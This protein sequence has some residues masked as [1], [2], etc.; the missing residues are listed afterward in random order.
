MVNMRKILSALLSATM[1]LLQLPVFAAGGDGTEQNP[2]KITTPEELQ[3]INQNLSAHYRL[4]NDLDLSGIDFEPLGNESVGAFT[5]TLDGNGFTVKNLTLEK[6]GNKYVGLVGCLE[7]TVKNIKLDNVTVN[8]QSARYVGSVAGFAEENALV[9]NC[10]TLS[11]SV[12]GSYVMVD[13]QLGGIAGYNKGTVRGCSNSVCINEEKTDIQ[14]NMVCGGIAGYNSGG[15]IENCEN[16]ADIFT[17]AS[18]NFT[19]YSYCGGIVGRNNIGKIVHCT[20]N[21]SISSRALSIYRYNNSYYYWAYSFSG[22]I[23]GHDSGTIL[24]CR[25]NGNISSYATSTQSSGSYGGSDYYSNSGAG[26]IAGAC[27]GNINK[28]INTGN[29]NSKSNSHKNY[30]GGISGYSNGSIISCDNLGNINADGSL[31]VRTS[32]YGGGIVGYNNTDIYHCV[33]YGKVYAKANDFGKGNWGGGYSYGGGIAGYSANGKVQSCQ[34]N[35]TIELYSTYDSY[36][37]GIVSQGTAYNCSNNSSIIHSGSPSTKYTYNIAPTAK[38]LYIKQPKINIKTNLTTAIPIELYGYDKDLKWTSADESIAVVDSKG[39]VTGVSAGE[40]IITAET[41]LGI[42]TSTT[43]VVSAESTGADIV[44]LNKI[45]ARL[46]P[47][48]TVQLTAEVTPADAT[49]P[50][51]WKSGDTS[52]ATVDA[53]GLVTAVKK[54]VT[55]I[56]ARIG[57]GRMFNCVINVVSDDVRVDVQSVTIH[58]SEITLAPND[59]AALNAVVSPSNATDAELKYTS[60]NED[61]ATVNAN[62]IVTAKS[63]GVAVIRAESSNGCYDEC[64]I[65]V[66]SADSASIVLNAEK[67]LSGDTAEVKA[68]I[69]KNP[70]I[71]AYKLNINYD[72]AA[73]TPVQ[74]T[75]NTDFKGTFTTNIE[76]ENKTN[77]Q[78]MWY[79]DEDTDLNAEL[80]NIT[81]K[82]SANAQIGDKYPVTAE[83]SAKDVYNTNGKHFAFYMQNTEIVVA[84]PL[85]GDIYEDG[86]VTAHDLTQLSRYVTHLEKLTNRQLVAADVNNDGAVNIKD[87]VR[88]SRY[89]VGWSGVELLSLPEEASGTPKI[90]FGNSAV[91]DEG[92]AEIPVSIQNNSGI[93][94]FVFKLDYNRDEVEILGITPNEK[95][96]ENLKTNLGKTDDD[97]LFVSWYQPTN[98]TENGEL[99]TIQ[100]RYLKDTASPVSIGYAD[101]CDKTEADIAIDY[102]SG[103]ILSDSFVIANE[104]L[105]NNAY[106]ADLYFDDTFKKQ[107]ATAIIAFY[108]SNNCL[109][110]CKTVDITVQPGMVDL[111]INYDEK[112][113]N[114]YKLRIWSRLDSMIPIT[115]IKQ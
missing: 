22:G 102:T 20:N 50:I 3:N 17:S 88:M 71:C 113:Y 82:V 99:F 54:G 11:G 81:F 101:I 109:V 31:S 26:G 58:D 76:D 78:I 105:E 90:A 33:N 98:M 79:S 63:A 61:V 42:T 69:V 52:I 103:A 25:N 39:N 27:A 51:T 104:K 91:N 35:S 89:L 21:N 5:G 32:G 56:T 60:D 8:G 83:D 114:S 6:E 106:T 34:N 97:G 110:Q 107:S 62:G 73:L 7:G 16:N 12:T 14:N 9:E 30:S 112:A 94:G 1:I 55:T 87:V 86:N 28:C 115:T 2:Y 37:G 23:S 64:V 96:S 80:F 67:S 111:S 18:S 74:V 13:F 85:P 15:Y 47:T 19:I 24:E 77:L 65:R 100:A 41:E 93:A 72:T 48:E 59:A 95:L 92:I 66:V 75:P 44:S 40:T 53:N 38:N 57:S 29:I 68:S 4:E 108:D 49:N 46:K 36:G 43:I 10:E 45:S 70:G 84:E